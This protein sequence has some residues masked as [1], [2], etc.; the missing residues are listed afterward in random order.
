MTC[1]NTS[2]GKNMSKITV[3]VVEN[4]QSKREQLEH[5]LKQNNNQGIEVLCDQKS[6]FDTN[7]E[8]RL[9]SRDNLSFKENTVARIK[10]L[11]PRVIF[12]NTQ[13]L[14]K[15]SC[16]LLLELHQKC[17]DTLPV[18]MVKELSEDNYVLQAL[19]CGAR[20]IVDC[21]TIN[22]D[23]SKI[24]QSVDNGE[25][26]VSRKILTKIMEKIVFTTSH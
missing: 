22:L 26:W 4:N 17:P 12:I 1:K 11:K 2:K 21:G 15:D 23:I 3:A 19:Q 9:K 7:N 25:P 24:I 5:Y 6:F 18:V 20:G 14:T 16:D 10:R 13:R 8:R